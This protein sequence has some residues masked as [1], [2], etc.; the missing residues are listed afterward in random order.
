MCRV[1]QVCALV[2]VRCFFLRSERDVKRTRE[3][4]RREREQEARASNK[5]KTTKQNALFCGWWEDKLD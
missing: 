3:R 2:W 1:F 5:N 4:E